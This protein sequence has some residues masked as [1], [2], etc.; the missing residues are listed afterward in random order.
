LWECTATS[1]ATAKAKLNLP[2]GSQNG[3]K[4]LVLG[5]NASG[6]VIVMRIG[7]LT[8]QG[9]SISVRGAGAVAHVHYKGLVQRPDGA[10]HSAVKFK[11]IPSFVIGQKGRKVWEVGRQDGNYMYRTVHR[12]K[13]GNWKTFKGAH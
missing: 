1:R 7:V 10:D 3:E 4:F 13:P 6:E 9:G 8:G 2:D 12:S 5:K 11:G